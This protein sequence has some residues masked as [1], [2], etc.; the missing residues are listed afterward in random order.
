MIIIHSHQVHD[1]LPRT[2]IV[3][4]GA[5][6]IASATRTSHWTFPATRWMSRSNALLKLGELQAEL[7]EL[8]HQLHVPLCIS[9]QVFCLP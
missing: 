4:S 6:T 5:S 8:L 2:R 9:A 3:P 1:P 7:L